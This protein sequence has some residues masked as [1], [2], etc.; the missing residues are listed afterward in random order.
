MSLEN[1]WVISFGTFHNWNVSF[2]WKHFLRFLFSD[3]QF[4]KLF[5]FIYSPVIVL[6]LVC[7]L[8]VP[9][10]IPPSPSLQEHVPPPT[11]TRP[12]HSLVP[13][14]SQWGLS[15]QSSVLY[16]LWALDQL[17]YGWWLSVWEISGFQVTLNCWSSYGFTPFPNFKMQFLV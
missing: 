13:Q 9:Q 10:L 5:L 12:P 8:S 1:S 17:I 11:P 4:L 3:L 15:W 14:F 6:L 2:N 16:V 7:P